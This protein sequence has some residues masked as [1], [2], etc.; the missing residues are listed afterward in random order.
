MNNLRNKV[1][2]IGR[3]GG[4]P[5]YT[6]TENGRALARFSLAVNSNYKDKT[7]N[8]V[9]DTQWHNINAWGKTADLVKRLLSKGQ[10][11]VVEGK[12]TNRTYET[13]TG[14]KRFSTTIEMNEFL[15]LNSKS[16]K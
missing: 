7:G 5:E 9:T 14:E 10:E 4:K 8:W 15:V 16:D 6:T 2:L 13:K 12:L 3:L 11:I 1:S